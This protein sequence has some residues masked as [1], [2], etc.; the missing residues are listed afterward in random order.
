MIGRVLYRLGLDKRNDQYAFYLI[1]R[2]DVVMVHIPKTAGTS[3]RNT[4]GMYPA[5][6]SKPDPG[7]KQHLTAQEI[8]EVIGRANWDEAFTFA[9]V[10]NPW[11]RMVSEY[12]YRSRH[13]RFKENGWDI[14]FEEYVRGTISDGAL[15]FDPPHKFIQPQVA[16]L[17]DKQGNICVDF[18]ARYE[19]LTTDFNTIKEKINRRSRPLQA[20]N[21]TSRN[22]DYTVYYSPELRDLV[23]AF[24]KEDIEYF[25]YAFT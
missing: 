5:D 14:S 23:G 18:I 25:G 24:Y 6:R 7:F 20:H 2:R 3:I 22:R 16:W 11:D 17:K 19:Q 9:V 15:P 8:I 4:L 12:H 21:R 13:K 1:G 10:R